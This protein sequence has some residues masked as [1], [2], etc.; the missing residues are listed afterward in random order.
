[1]PGPIASP[2]SLMSNDKRPR[3]VGNNELNK[4][5]TWLNANAKKIYKK[6]AEEIKK[7]GIA[8][9]CDTNIL[10]I[11]SAQLDRLQVV[12]QLPEKEL[13]QERL[14]NDL[15][16][17]VLSLSKELG[18]TPSARAKLRIAKVEVDD[19]DSFLSDE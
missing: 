11:F 2:D 4:A 3:T 13:F 15:T 9:R 7:L 17:S 16:S 1:M 6:T 8:D 10:A 18:I 19:I 14:Q 5:P 12:S